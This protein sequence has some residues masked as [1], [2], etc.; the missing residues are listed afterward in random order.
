VDEGS[1]EEASK[2]R[3]DRIVPRIELAR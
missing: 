3:K 1:N 2:S